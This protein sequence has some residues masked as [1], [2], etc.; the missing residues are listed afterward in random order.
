VIRR[1]FRGILSAMGYSLQK[2][3]MESHDSDQIISRALEQWRVTPRSNPSFR[4]A[5]WSRIEAVRGDLSWSGYARA[6]AAVLG[7][8]L[9][10]ALALGGWVGRETARSRVDADRAEIASAYV[11]ALDARLM[12]M[13]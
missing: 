6:H 9:A 1:I 8:A 12:T 10:L 7:G 4:A 3:I 2:D 5:V 11:Q 13:P